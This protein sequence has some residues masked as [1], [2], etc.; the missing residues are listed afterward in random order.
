M[1]GRVNA[2][3]IQGLYIKWLFC[4]V[5]VKTLENLGKIRCPGEQ[6]SGYP[7]VK[8]NSVFVRPTAVIIFAFIKMAVAIL[9]TDLI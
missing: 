9:N 2:S 6:P 8:S 7:F 1:T 4:V 3:S 5:S